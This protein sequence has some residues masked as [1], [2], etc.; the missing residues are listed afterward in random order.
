MMGSLLSVEI[1]NCTKITVE[2][3]PFV[4]TTILSCT[5]SVPSHYMIT[6][7]IKLFFKLNNYEPV[8]HD[9]RRTYLVLFLTFA[10][11]T[12]FVLIY[13]LLYKI[14]ILYNSRS[15]HKEI[16]AGAQTYLLCLRARGSISVHFYKK[17][18]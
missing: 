18:L 13:L 8:R 12:G 7:D 6:V 17:T 3:N 9:L 16:K 10:N 15:F 5:A 1:L 14:F 11:A 4:I 2:L